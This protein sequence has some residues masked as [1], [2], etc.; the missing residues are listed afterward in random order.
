MCMQDMRWDNT[1]VREL[2]GDTESSNSLRQVKQSAMRRA[3]AV[4]G[5]INVNANAR[6]DLSAVSMCNT[7][8]VTS[9]AL[10]VS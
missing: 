1:F 6:D 9:D 3:A 4:C 8:M 7:G 2:P 5:G 10:Q